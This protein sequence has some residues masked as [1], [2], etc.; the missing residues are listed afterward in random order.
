M[1]MENNTSSPKSTTDEQPSL[2][3]DNNTLGVIAHVGGLLTSF[4]VPL[5]IWLMQKDK[6]GNASANALEALNFQITIIIASA[7]AMVLSFVFIGALLFPVITVADL[8]FAIMGAVAASKG[9]VYRYPYG[10]RLVK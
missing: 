6:G 9:E 1:H 8:V 5:V 3:I 10:L 7:V 2:T 4:V